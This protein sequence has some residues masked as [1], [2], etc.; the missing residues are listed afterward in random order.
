VLNDTIISGGVII[1]TVNE[2]TT[3]TSSSIIDISRFNIYN[4]PNTTVYKGKDN[5]N[6][7]CKY[8]LWYVLL[9]ILILILLIVIIILSYNYKNN[10]N[11]IVPNS[12]SGVFKPNT[13]TSSLSSVS[14]S[15]FDTSSQNVYGDIGNRFYNNAV[16]EDVADYNIEPKRITVNETYGSLHETSID[17][18][19]TIR[20]NYAY[21]KHLSANC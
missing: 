21:V 11:K 17:N 12:N 18:N 19:N 20:P 8:T 15:S 14:T 3:T 13:N 10:D 1:N 9:I 2:S 5:C 7:F 16:Y 4:T 6:D